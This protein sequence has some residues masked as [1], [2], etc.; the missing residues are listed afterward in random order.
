MNGN[1]RLMGGGKGGGGG[2]GKTSVVRI[3]HFFVF[4]GGF[5]LEG[6]IFKNF[7]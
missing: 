1:V 3:S 7:F 5:L 4:G 6:A 2:S